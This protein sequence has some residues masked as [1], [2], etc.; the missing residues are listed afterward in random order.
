MLPDFL[1]AWGRVDGRI[2]PEHVMVT[3]PTRS[4]KSRF[5]RTI[6]QAR[7]QLRGS[8][9]CMIAT[10]PE[11]KTLRDYGWPIIRKWPPPYG[12]D[13]FI[14]WVQ[15]HRDPDV[16]KKIQ[17]AEIRHVLHELWTPG[18]NMIVG[19]DELAYLDDSQELNLKTM[20]QRYWREASALGITV[21]AGT[22]RPRFVSLYG[23]TESQWMAAFR[24]HDEMDGKRVAEVMGSKKVYYDQL[25]TLRHH[26]FILRH[27]RT[28][29]EVI[30]KIE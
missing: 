15:T 7:A 6:L 20:T 2:E 11:D 25:M 26:E 17:R 1:A 18:A 4:G 10:K 16:N 5:V 29:Q 21:V 13:Q 3:G 22:Q 24:P 28:R 14:F 8:H 9:V 27:I 30:T 12:T 23:F 19:F